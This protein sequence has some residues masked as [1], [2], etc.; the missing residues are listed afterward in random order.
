MF[1]PPTPEHVE[2]DQRRIGQFSTN[3][4]E[5]FEE[6]R[7]MLPVVLCV[8]VLCRD[9]CE[10]KV[11]H[12]H[13][14]HGPGESGYGPY[15]SKEEEVD[16]S[17]VC[18]RCYFKQ[19]RRLDDLEEKKRKLL[20]RDTP[21]SVADFCR[22][23]QEEIIRVIFGELPPTSQKLLKYFLPLQ[24]DSPIPRLQA[25]QDV[26][27]EQ[28]LVHE[29]ALQSRETRGNSS[30]GASTLATLSP[31][32]AAE[33]AP[34]AAAGGAIKKK[35]SPS[36][37]EKKKK[38]KKKKEGCVH[39][40]R[41]TPPLSPD[42]QKEEEEREERDFLDRL[43]EVTKLFQ[44]NNAPPP[45]P[46]PPL[47]QPRE[48]EKE[49]REEREERASEAEQLELLL[50]PENFSALYRR[51]KNVIGEGRVDGGSLETVRE[52]AP[53]PAPAPANAFREAVKYKE[54]TNLIP[55]DKALE[56]EEKELSAAAETVVRSD[57]CDVSSLADR[58][59]DIVEQ[60]T[61]VSN[62]RKQ[63]REVRQRLNE[64]VE[65]AERY[66]A[67]RQEAERL[68]K[69]VEKSE[70]EGG[71]K[72][73]GVSSSDSSGSGEKSGGDDNSPSPLVV[74]LRHEMNAWEKKVEEHDRAK[75]EEEE[76]EKEEDEKKKE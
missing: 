10:L 51:A 50:E 23:R 37:V 67:L 52:K 60:A 45:P 43:R 22:L 69:I 33:L 44:E 57:A 40:H 68:E 47:Q 14:P 65:R 35:P 9:I 1:E 73:S 42:P 8:C 62:E 74:T 24:E 63:I 41:K 32:T 38:K 16:L 4:Y 13:V 20:Y 36:T 15:G 3:T 30:V 12:K 49:E 71:D 72:S 27:G 19:R 59:R 39:C 28:R 75:K 55:R 64:M 29:R 58:A 53:V 21:A 6:K 25:P 56:K 31:S 17:F 70:A 61:Y 5:K 54:D 2:G 76:E 18:R 34:V 48:E 26:A 66:D 7:A 11:V 46:P